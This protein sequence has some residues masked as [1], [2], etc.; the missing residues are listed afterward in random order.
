[1]DPVTTAIVAAVGK[2]GETAVGDA[3]RYL[4]KLI[5]AKC[6]RGS[7]IETAME[8]LEKKPQ[9]KG[10]QTTLQEEVEDAALRDES[11]ILEAAQALLDLTAASVDNSV[12]EQHAGQDAVSVHQAI[13][14]NHNLQ[15]ANGDIHV[16]KKEVV[17]P[18]YPREEGDITE[19][20]A[21]AIKVLVDKLVDIDRKAGRGATYGEWWPRF[22]KRFHIT[23]YKKLPAAKFDDAITWLRQQKA[24]SRPKLR[25]TDNKAWRTELYAGLWAKWLKELGREKADIYPLAGELLA[26]KKPITSLKQLGE[27]NLQDLHDHI[28]R[29]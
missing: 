15:T 3:Y 5:V 21:A 8:D 28:M 29:M 7:D 13:T 26:L 11:A 9:S 20:Q 6:G 4:K 25:R 12:V 17:R 18:V 2:V 10:R 1:M 19:E 14:G 27:R 24:Q 22:C 16:N 23:A